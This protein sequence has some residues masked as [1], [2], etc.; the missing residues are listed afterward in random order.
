MLEQGKRRP[1]TTTTASRDKAD[2]K[3]IICYNCGEVGHRSMTCPKPWK[4]ESRKRDEMK[5]VQI[6]P[7]DR[8]VLSNNEIMA[9]T[10]GHTFPVTIDTGD[11]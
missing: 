3:P 6:S 5:R 1:A 11:Q 4:Y 8:G 7:K 2:V 9:E 10:S